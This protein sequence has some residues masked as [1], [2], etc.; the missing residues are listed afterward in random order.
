MVCLRDKRS[1]AS[2]WDKGSV[3]I[4]KV[5]K[6]NFFLT[7]FK[8]RPGLELSKLP[9]FF[10]AITG[11]NHRSEALLFIGRG[12]KNALSLRHF[13]LLRFVSNIRNVNV[14]WRAMQERTSI[15]LIRSKS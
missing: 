11:L 8:E 9:A 3:N 1:S 6:N 15:L 5:L 7:P 12:C 10:R 2:K 13:Y 4:A 14:Y